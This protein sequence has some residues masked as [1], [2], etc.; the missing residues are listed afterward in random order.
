MSGLFVYLRYLDP[1][2]R[3]SNR[4]ISDISFVLRETTLTLIST[5]VAISMESEI[6]LFPL[7]QQKY[8]R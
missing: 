7:V 8:P 5:G 2:D 1:E 6:E 4:A 3:F